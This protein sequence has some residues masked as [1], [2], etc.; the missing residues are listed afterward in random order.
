VARPK[1]FLRILLV[2][3][4]VLGV[5]G[6]G[7]L[8]WR[9]DTRL[10]RQR[11]V[12]DIQA[13]HEKA[14]PR[15]VQASPSVP[16][17]FGPLASAPWTALAALQGNS[18]DVDFCP[19]APDGG[20]PEAE[21]RRRCDAALVQGAEALHA[22]LLSTHAE[23]A[24]PPA[25]LG[26]LDTPAPA[27]AP[28]TFGTAG[29]AARMAAYAVQSAS[30]PPLSATEGSLSVLLCVDLLALAR[31]LSWGTA[32]EGRL[33]ALTVTDVAFFPCAKALDA[34][35]TDTQRKAG[36]ALARV[37][38]GTPGLDETLAEWSVA[39]RAQLFAPYLAE[40]LPSLPDAV[41]R[42]ARARLP[43]A[44]RGLEEAVAFGAEWHALQS[45]LD[46][47]VEAARLPGPEAA[48]RLSALSA[49]AEP[50]FRALGAGDFPDLGSVAA[51]E[52]HARTQLL[53]LRRVTEV[54]A[55]RA[56]TGVWPRPDSLPGA[57]RSTAAQP[58]TLEEKGRTA[59]LRDATSPRGALEV[60]LSPR[61][62]GR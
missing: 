34:A 54:S 15:P 30:V 53:L 7:R 36:A 23:A 24:G 55:L 8:A 35:G 10:L 37:V 12:R 61:P 27:L 42:W 22:L 52:R 26:A 13:F 32:L 51:S 46:A 56:E 44:Q 16:G 39:L 59:V 49:A 25:G 57:L 2:G 58:F 43:P 14:Y 48:E 5:A 33:A 17:R 62:Q 41:Q 31:D 11:L 18:L 20:A 45:R 29:Y 6:L 40:A 50:A 28:R 38:E 19:E 60:R 3:A 1:R 47:V 21:A 4:F 9:T